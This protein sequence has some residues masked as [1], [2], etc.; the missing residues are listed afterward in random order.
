MSISS[1]WSR[2]HGWLLVSTMILGLGI[3]STVQAQSRR[4]RD[5]SSGDRVRRLTE[6]AAQQM[7]D[8]VAK[9]LS[10]AAKIGAKDPVRAARLLK[11]TL[12]RVEDNS[13]L[14]EKQ[15]DELIARLKGAVKK[16]SLAADSRV[17][18]DA[19]REESKNISKFKKSTGDRSRREVADEAEKRIRSTG[20]NLDEDKRIKR[21]KEKGFTSVSRDVDKSS[22]PTARTV[23]FDPKI[24]ARVVKRKTVNLTKKELAILK[25]LN[26]VIS[27]DF[28]SEKFEAVIDYLMDKTGQVILL[29][30]ES[31]KEKEIDYETP[32][33]LK[34]N[35]ISVRALLRKILNDL[36]L[37]YIIK[38]EAIQVTT[39]EKAKKLMV[40]RSYPVGD[41]VTANLD[42]RL[43]PALKALAMQQAANQVIELIKQMVEPE[44]WA[45]SETGGTGT[46]V[47][48][49]LTLTITVKQ[50]AEVHY[51]LSQFGR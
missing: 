7:K 38:D 40:V 16:W 17:K 8:D 36:G 1:S 35:K 31:L 9:V 34:V 43:P 21:E 29:D 46:I 3:A 41:L 12:A 2:R 42:P 14:T 11:A 50:S 24:W 20:D 23:T 45:G 5:D 22:I 47:F 13:D 18:E 4:E 51:M 6:I 15:R 19:D 26:S 33:T 48:N 30:K 37:T 44:S 25:I 27:V 49:P 39:L 10:D 32:V 28:K